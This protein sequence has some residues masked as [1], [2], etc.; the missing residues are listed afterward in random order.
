MRGNTDKQPC[1]VALPTWH[2]QWA[3]SHARPLEQQVKQGLTPF[4][5]LGFLGSMGILHIVGWPLVPRSH[6]Q[7][8]EAEEGASHEHK[9]CITPADIPSVPAEANIQI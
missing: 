6:R 4:T 5:Y 3:K 2:L 7:H 9:S 8:R 1:Q